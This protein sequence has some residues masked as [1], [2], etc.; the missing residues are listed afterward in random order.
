MSLG[1]Y[2]YP[3]YLYSVVTQDNLALQMWYIYSKFQSTFEK[4]CIFIF[5]GEFTSVSIL[6]PL[7]NTFITILM[8]IKVLDVL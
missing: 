7:L 5:C 1:D 8:F 2:Y 3:F 4:G 6:E